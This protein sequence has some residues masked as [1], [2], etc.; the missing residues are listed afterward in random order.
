MKRVEEGSL[1]FLPQTD[2]VGLQAIGRRDID[3][4][5]NERVE[6]EEEPKA[7]EVAGMKDKAADYNGENDIY[8]GDGGSPSLSM[9]VILAVES[10]SI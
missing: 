3:Y 2:A 5:K 7:M 1:E 8:G 9:M 10:I 4:N 6:V